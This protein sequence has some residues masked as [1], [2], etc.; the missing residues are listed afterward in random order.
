MLNQKHFSEYTPK[1]KP[2]SHKLDLFASHIIYTEL[3]P[4][5]LTIIKRK[6]VKDMNM[7]LKKEIQMTN[8]Y[9]KKYIHH[10]YQRMVN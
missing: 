2:E 4:E 1:G 8:K 5:H 7:P 10:S 3:Y 9:I 6:R